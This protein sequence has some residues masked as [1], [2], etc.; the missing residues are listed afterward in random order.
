MVMILNVN[1]MLEMEK[2]TE[3]KLETLCLGHL[4]P[5]TDKCKYCVADEYNKH[6]PHY[7]EAR[8]KIFE[9]RE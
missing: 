6:C 1:V 2:T 5:M 4:I 7:Q 9:V 8:V 3:G